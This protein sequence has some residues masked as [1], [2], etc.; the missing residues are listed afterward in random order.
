MTFVTADIGTAWLGDYDL[1]K[2]ILKVCKDTGIDALKFQSLS[3]ELLVRHK[4]LDYYRKA[5]IDIHNVA[6]VAEWCKDYGI[7]FYSTVT[8]PNAAEILVP[9]VN[10]FKIRCVDNQN[11]EIYNACVNKAKTVIISSLRPLIDKFYSV[12]NLY[13]IPRYPVDLG[14]INFELMKEFDGYSNHCRNPLAVLVNNVDYL[15][16]HITPT[17]DIFTLDNTVSYTPFEVGQIMRLLK[18]K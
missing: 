9:F 5:S 1:L 6:T 2:N 12:I 14:E 18:R 10:K 15:E 16:F 3:E 17:S 11:K 7:E 13:C 4:E 8:Y